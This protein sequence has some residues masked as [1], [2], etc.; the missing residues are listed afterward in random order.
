MPIE[1]KALAVEEMD[2]AGKGLAR[3]ATLSAVDHDGDAYARGAFGWTEQWVPILPAHDRHAMPFGKA[4][5]F[6][7]GCLSD[8]RE[9][10]A[11]RRA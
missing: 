2:E 9:P 1:T 7:E 11:C 8:V 6:E 4:R 5:I 3:I 10:R